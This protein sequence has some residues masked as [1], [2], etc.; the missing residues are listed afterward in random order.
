[1]PLKKPAAH[2]VHPKTFG[3]QP[4]RQTQVVPGKQHIQEKLMPFLG[5]SMHDGPPPALAAHVMHTHIAQRHAAILCVDLGVIADEH[6][7]C[8]WLRPQHCIVD[9]AAPVGPVHSKSI[10]ALLQEIG[11][12]VCMPARD[13]LHERLLYAQAGYA[14]GVFGLSK[15]AEGVMNANACERLHHKLRAV[16]YPFSQASMSGVLPAEVRAFM[17]SFTNLPQVSMLMLGSL[18][19]SEPWQPTTSAALLCRTSTTAFSTSRCPRAAARAYMSIWFDVQSHASCRP[20]LVR[21]S[22]IPSVTELKSCRNRDCYK[23]TALLETYCTSGRKASTAGLTC[24]VMHDIVAI[25]EVRVIRQLRTNLQHLKQSLRH[26]K[27]LL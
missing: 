19:F 10:C 1:M 22:G 7:Q 14:H 13:H 8:I 25:S 21:I 27:R 3:E 18:M 15:D 24:C 20:I 16:A 11:C 6:P 26:C 5:V 9:G 4:A 17:T 12:T 2:R 23:C